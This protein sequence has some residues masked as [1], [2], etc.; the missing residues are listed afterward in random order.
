MGFWRCWAMSVGIMI[1]SGIFLLPAVLAP[2]GAISLLGWLVTS[3]AVICLALVLGRLANRTTGSGGP[4]AFCRTAFGDLTG[5]LIAWAYWLSV[6]LAI[7][8]VAIAFAGYLGALLPALRNP[9]AQAA[10]ALCAIWSLT[11]LNVHGISAA[12]SVQ[13]ALTLLKIV[14]LLIIIALGAIAGSVA[15]LPPF[16]PTDASITG[17]ISATALLTMWAFTG[18]EG[19]VIPAADVRDPQHTIPRAVFWAAVSVAAL[20]ILATVAV[21]MLVPAATLSISQAPF[22]DAAHL[23]GPWGTTLIGIGALLA[24]L[25]S[26]NGDI[27]VGGQMPMAV[28]QDN[29]APKVL[30][31]RNSGNAPALPLIA[32]SAAASVILALNYADELI[33]VFTLLITMSTLCTLAPYAISALAELKHSWRSARGWALLPAVT[34]AFIV[35]AASGSGLTVILLGVLLGAAGIPLFYVFKRAK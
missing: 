13:L 29:L 26:L 19:A 30:A 17:A 28:A 32:S 25:G 9:A 4:Y 33:G 14:P 15:T 7:A 35:L 27:F 31:H 24:T 12:A 18:I 1:G 16:N 5:F 34:T 20:Y 8:A 10:V 6:V 11:A 21:M 2:Y 22:V 3:V 23:L